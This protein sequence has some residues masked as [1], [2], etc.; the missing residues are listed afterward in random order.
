M[1]FEKFLNG[2]SKEPLQV[3]DSSI[4]INDYTGIDL[5]IHNKDIVDKD[6]SIPDVCENYINSKIN[7]RNAK[8]AYGGYLEE[9]NLYQGLNNF[10]SSENRTIHLGI[11]LWCKVGTEVLAVLDGAVHSF[12][13]NNKVGDYG[14][15]LILKHSYNSIEFHTLYGHL[16]LESI[17]GIEI[18]QKLSQ[19][20]VIGALGSPE[21]NVGYAPHLHFQLIRNM[22]GYFGDYPGVCSKEDL[23]FY[24]ENCPNPDL[25]LKLSSLKR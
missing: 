6:V 24:K 10:I 2:I 18:E 14:P 11:D 16:S 9:R 5:S 25:L 4:S 8:V 7:S 22:T 13:N 21:F 20:D 17:E 1:N 3:I 15:T 23:A 19:G 12:Q